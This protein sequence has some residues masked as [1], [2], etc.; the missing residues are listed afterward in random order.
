MSDPTD[1][2]PPSAWQLASPAFWAV[3]IPTG[4]WAAGLW[5][6]QTWGQ[7]GAVVLMAWPLATVAGACLGGARLIE[8][9]APRIRSFALAWVLTTLLVIGAFGVQVFL[10]TRMGSLRPSTPAAATP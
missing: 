2:T 9:I 7:A 10:A 5:A 8:L 4:S 6:T 3:V 1:A